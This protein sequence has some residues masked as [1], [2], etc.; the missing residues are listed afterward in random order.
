[1]VKTR[2]KNNFSAWHVSPEEFSEDMTSSEK[3]LY[4]TKYAILAPSGHN[5]Q[6]WLIEESGKSIDIKINQDHHLSIDGS[7]ML[8]VEP[9][10]SIG[11]FLEV[12]NLAGLGFG[13]M[14]NI[15]LFPVSTVVATV[16]IK[17]KTKAIPSLLEAITNRVS[18]RNPFE[19]QT[20]EKELLR[21]LV[22]ANFDG[23]ATKTVTDRS[24]VSFISEQTEHAVKSIMSKPAYREELSRWVRT[25]QTRRYDG[26]P[27]FTH[28][29]G[30]I[31]SLASKFA[32][33]RGVKL[34]PQAK[35][36]K[37]LILASGALIVVSC[38]D[39]SKNSFVNAGRTYSSICVL[40]TKNGLATS[41]LGASV[42]DPNTRSKIKKHFK[43]TAR[44]I[45]IL[46]LGTKSKIASHSPRYP[47]ELVTSP[48]KTQG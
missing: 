17:R 45:Y 24:D 31:K 46:R 41:A 38:L 7:G 35:H 6:P 33:K 34:G 14:L 10:I 1:M 40:A 32:V 21:S 22:S 9:Y 26:M 8:S 43:I 13:Y 19:P 4:F 18:N 29:F 27:G 42:V 39:S 3:L 20:I 37:E 11:T 36:S 16:S 47:A 44:P 12:L 15:R 30:N 28:G 2:L 5:T 23:V 48:L 25:N